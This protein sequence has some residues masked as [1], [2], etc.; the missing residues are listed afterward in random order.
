VSPEDLYKN[1]V[2]KMPG[3]VTR[4]LAAAMCRNIKKDLTAKGID[5]K[6]KSPYIS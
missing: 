4:V 2:M 1:A 3:F 5:Y 6:A